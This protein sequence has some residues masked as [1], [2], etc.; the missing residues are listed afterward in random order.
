MGATQHVTP[1]PC[2][3]SNQSVY[4]HTSQM[5]LPFH[6]HAQLALPGGYP[7][8]HLAASQ[9][10]NGYK[11][12]KTPTSAVASNKARPSPGYPPPSTARI[13]G[14][15][16]T[17]YPPPPFSPIT[18]FRSPPPHVSRQGQSSL[19]HLSASQVRS[20][21]QMPSISSKKASRQKVII[22]GHI[23]FYSNNPLF[24]MMKTSTKG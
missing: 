17:S 18:Q 4:P 1:V 16:L 5:Y 11:S 6:P 9:G 15:P 8:H 21:Q 7:V 12:P 2:N 19:T 3:A 24:R 13:S 10:T 20:E 14:P 23:V 22:C